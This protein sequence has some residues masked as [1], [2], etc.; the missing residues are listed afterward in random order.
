M[1]G[2]MDINAFGDTNR[3]GQDHLNEE[4]SPCANGQTSCGHENHDVGVKGEAPVVPV[5]S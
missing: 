5:N 3:K 2:Y 1:A 4:S